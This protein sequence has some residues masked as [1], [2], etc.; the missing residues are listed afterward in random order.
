[1]YVLYPY[2]DTPYL[3]FTYLKSAI[4][5]NQTKTYLMISYSYRLYMYI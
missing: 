3:L 1:M 4:T 2:D 5:Y